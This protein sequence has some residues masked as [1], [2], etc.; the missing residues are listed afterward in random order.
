MKKRECTSYI[1][2]PFLVYIKSRFSHYTAFM[3]DIF[4]LLLFNFNSS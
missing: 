3:F 1:D 2:V 4:L